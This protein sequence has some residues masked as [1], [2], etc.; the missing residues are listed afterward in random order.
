MNKE[1]F[2]SVDIESN[3]PIPGDYSMLSLG[4]ASFSQNG[5]LLSTF[6]VNLKDLSGA[7]ADP[8][9]M[10]WWATNQEAYDATRKD[11]VD[12]K[13]AMEQY[14]SWIKEQPGSPVFVGYPAGFDFLFIYWYLIHFTGESPFSFSALDIKTY[15]MAVLKTDYRKSTKKNMP[16][17]WFPEDK[18]THV[19]VDDAIEQG[20]LFCN[21]LKE[22]LA[23]AP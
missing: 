6:T 2:I 9:T 7:K 20:K 11:M 8:D 12:P 23:K 10:A 17:R 16:K 21:I 15:V 22:N 13:L 5:E 18:H 14:V 1:V 19:A 3:G 4:A